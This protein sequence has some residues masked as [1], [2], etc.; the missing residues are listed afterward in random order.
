MTWLEDVLR[1]SLEPRGFRVQTV[2]GWQTRGK[3][4]PGMPRFITD[5]HTASS[6]RSGPS[7]SLRICIYGRPG[8]PGPLCHVHDSRDGVTTVV[9]A[10]RAN[11]AGYGT[12]PDGSNP[13]STSVGRE[14]ENDGLGEPWPTHQRESQVVG[15]AAIL[16]HLG[17]PADHAL[18]HREVDPRRKIDPTYDMDDHRRRVAQQMTGGTTPNPEELDM[19]EARLRQIIREETNDIRRGIMLDEA[20]DEK[21]AEAGR[22][23]YGSLRGWVGA[24][25]EKVGVTREDAIRHDPTVPKG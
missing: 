14:S 15:D 16:R 21:V 11:H 12:N 17:Q 5:H 13:N 10:G 18:G 8:L 4:L 6:R 25:A 3:P 23:N 1:R 19:D 22:R 9:A 2:T 20:S 7:G 24:I